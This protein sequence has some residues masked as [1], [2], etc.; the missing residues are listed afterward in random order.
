MGDPVKNKTPFESDS[1][2]GDGSSETSDSFFNNVEE[3]HIKN[4]IHNKTEHDEKVTPESNVR[5]NSYHPNSAKN[6]A[7]H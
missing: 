3:G 4:R 1:D 5:F 7:A 2:N 6:N